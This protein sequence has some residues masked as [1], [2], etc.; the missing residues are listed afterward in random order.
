VARF[1]TFDPYYAPALRR[2]SDD[3]LIPDAWVYTLVGLA[4][5]AAILTR[6]RP[7][8]GMSATVLVLLLSALTALAEGLGH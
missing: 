5:T 1:Y 7:R 2:M 8:L 3:G 6:T 4:L